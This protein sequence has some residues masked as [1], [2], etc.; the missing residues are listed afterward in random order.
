[1]NT[2]LLITLS[3]LDR[4]GLVSEVAEV[5][6][7]LEANWEQ[8]RMLHLADRF[9]GILEV[10]VRPVRTEALI[11]QLKAIKDLEMTIATAK[12]SNPPQPQV[13]LNL[14][15]SDHPGIVRAIF[16]VIGDSKVNVESLRT[17][18]EPA[19]DSGQ[20]LFKAH[21]LLS[22]PKSSDLDALQDA[23]ENIS[24][25]VMVTLGRIGG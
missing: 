11:E 24:Q 13:E 12:P 6:A 8:S 14:M 15:G 21:A 25:D 4:P 23:L 2:V 9:I 3:G 7:G 18:T 20:M 16:G 19:P 17:H 22:A 10:H 1:M 5:I